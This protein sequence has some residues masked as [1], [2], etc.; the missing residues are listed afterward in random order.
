MAHSRKAVKFYETI[1]CVCNKSKVQEAGSEVT[2]SI[3]TLHVFPCNWIRIRL[4]SGILKVLFYTNVKSTT[5]FLDK[6]KEQF[7][8][9]K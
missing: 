3:W 2:N 5:L 1:G 8:S 7:L 6:L 4:R 9:K